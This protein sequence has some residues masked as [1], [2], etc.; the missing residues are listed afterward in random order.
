M[1]TADG[2]GNRRVRMCEKYK[3]LEKW[4]RLS[5]AKPKSFRLPSQKVLFNVGSSISKGLSMLCSIME[6]TTSIA[7]NSN[8]QKTH[9]ELWR[10][11]GRISFCQMSFIIFIADFGPK[12]SFFLSFYVEGKNRPFGSGICWVDRSPKLSHKHILY[13]AEVGWGHKDASVSHMFYNLKIMFFKLA[14]SSGE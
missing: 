13:T 8:G 12:P 9:G 4:W 14:S 11:N 3:V 2:I 7:K 10:Y 5:W 6:V 1:S